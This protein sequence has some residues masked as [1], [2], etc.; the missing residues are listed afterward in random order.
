LPDNRTR[1]PPEVH[2]L[3]IFIMVCLPD[4][5]TQAEGKEDAKGELVDFN[6]NIIGRLLNKAPALVG[7]FLSR[8]GESGKFA[9]RQPVL[10]R[11]GGERVRVR[12]AI[13]KTFAQEWRA[14]IIA[15]DGSRTDYEEG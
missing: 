2:N 6:V 4:N 9:G 3:L 7:E 14:R 15:T 12:G 11:G 13:E 8:P 10:L 5:R 1:K